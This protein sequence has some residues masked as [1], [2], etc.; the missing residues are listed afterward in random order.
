MGRFSVWRFAGPNDQ[1]TNRGTALL[2]AAPGFEPGNKGFAVPRLCRLATPPRLVEVGGVEPPSENP[3]ASASTSLARVLV[4]GRRAP[5]GGI[6]RPLASLSFV[7]AAQGQPP[8]LARLVD[9]QRHPTGGSA[10]DGLRLVQG[11]SRNSCVVG[12]CLPFRRI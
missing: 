5:T 1:P 9:A 6:A 11:V 12:V 10:A 7:Q 2:E 3:L 8:E 4:L